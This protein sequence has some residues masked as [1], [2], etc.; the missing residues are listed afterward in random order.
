MVTR[1]YP[2]PNPNQVVTRWYRAPELL[3]GAK[4]YGSPVDLWS[5]GTILA[6][7]LLGHLPFQGQDSTQQVPPPLHSRPPACLLTTAD[8]YYQL[9]TTTADY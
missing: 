4:F 1:W 2:N 6:E 5:V 9:P 8:Y 7:L 3:F